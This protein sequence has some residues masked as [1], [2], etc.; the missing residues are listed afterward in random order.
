MFAG[1]PKSDGGEGFNFYGLA[2]QRINLILPLRNGLRSLFDEERFA[3]SQV[4]FRYLATSPN[5]DSE[6]NGT[7][8]SF[9]LSLYRV[10]G[11]DFFNRCFSEALSAM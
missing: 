11:L 2:I 10:L 8:D 9:G 5:D 4:H 1:E 7:F 3:S 6:N